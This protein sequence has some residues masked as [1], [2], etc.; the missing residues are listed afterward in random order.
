MNMRFTAM[1]FDVF[2][3]A[4]FAERMDAI[5]RQIRP[6]LVTVG[7]QLTPWLEHE[8]GLEFYYHVATHARRRVNPPD[9]TWVAFGRSA[10]GYKRFLHLTVAID[11]LGL[12]TEL[13]VKPE[14]DDKAAFAEALIRL[15]AQGTARLLG[16]DGAPVYW[17]DEREGGIPMTAMS[18][19]DFRQR[20]E[21]LLSKKSAG[22]TLGCRL[23]KEEVLSWES[24]VMIN[25]LRNHL[26]RLIPLYLLPLEMPTRT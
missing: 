14:S 18:E 17:L 23:S 2:T 26:N 22:A 21:S 12:K 16:N 1:D 24:P 10:R 7:E 4:G 11:R 25:K 13:V 19:T 6:K 8:T 5:R 3:I 15:G 20:L 9:D